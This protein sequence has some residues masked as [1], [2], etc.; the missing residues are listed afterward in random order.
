MPIVTSLFGLFRTL[1]FP[2]QASKN[3]LSKATIRPKITT[4]VCSVVNEN[5]RLRI[6]GLIENTLS[7]LPEII[8]IGE[9]RKS[10]LLTSAPQNQ[11]DSLYFYLN[12]WS[13]K[14]NLEFKENAFIFEKNQCRKTFKSEFL[15]RNVRNSNQTIRKGGTCFC[16]VVAF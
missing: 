10:T 7:R 13:M 9:K 4:F 8:L 12:H 2:R 14:Y 15:T 3:M 5:L 11:G 1:F 6:L 16:L